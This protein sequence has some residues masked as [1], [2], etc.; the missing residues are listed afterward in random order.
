MAYKSLD[1]VTVSD[2]EALGIESEA[3]KRLHAS[4]TNII[5]NYGP[6]TPDTWRNIT[7]RVLSPELPF[8]FHQMLYYGCYKVFGPDPPAWLPD[9]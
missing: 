9:S 3:A 8:S 4:L 1:R 5:Q 7:A 2:I 6:A